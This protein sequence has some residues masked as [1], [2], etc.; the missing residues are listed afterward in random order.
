MNQKTNP[1]SHT[2]APW[3]VDEST[4]N[5]N[6]NFISISTDYPEA[7]CNGQ[8][9][10]AV[11]T[12]RKSREPEIHTANRANAAHI[13][14]C[15]NAHDELVSALQQIIEKYEGDPDD[16]ETMDLGV[17]IAES[18]LKKAGAK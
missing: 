4:V 2:P 8:R 13:V 3:K 12:G 7:L 10:I 11:M 6:P 1:A 16:L 15:V 14:L 17:K 9:S 18:A 5:Q